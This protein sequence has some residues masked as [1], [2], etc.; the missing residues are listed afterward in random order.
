MTG[1]SVPRAGPPAGAPAPLQAVTF[2]LG[3]T[4]VEYEHVP[5]E[6]LEA[7][8]WRGLYRRL[9]EGERFRHLAP[10]LAA[11]TAD[12]FAGAMLSAS[13]RAWRRAGDTLQSAALQGIL[14]GGL[15][16]LGLGAVAAEDFDDLAGHFHD[17][18]LDLVSVYDD[19]LATLAALRHR[20]IKLGLISNTVWPGRLHTR[21]LRR[22]G[23]DSF[24]D[25]LTYSSEHP[26]TK[27]H[28]AIFRDTLDRLG[29]V[30]P[31]AALHV[32]DRILD[33]VRGAQ[34]AGMRGVLKA[35]P[36]RGAD[37]ADGITPD[38]RIDRL[39]ELPAVLDALF[40]PTAP[41]G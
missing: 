21:D 30:P 5:W 39:A 2:D 28:P 10:G 16:A 4:L 19:S 36:R 12:D 7:T 40:P 3:G 35:H 20:G 38:A 8:G 37:P 22:F 23:L 1:Q 17:A 29:G 24:F 18:T 6:E 9:R 33:D 41:A 26:H 27:P 14:A 11:G 25:V 34:G 31:E 13:G 32:G 15:T